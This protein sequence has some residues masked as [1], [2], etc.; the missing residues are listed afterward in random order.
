[1]EYK[2]TTHS[3]FE[4]IELAQNFESE[5][6]PNMVICLDGELGSGK[7]VF[8]K[9][10]GNALGINESITSPT[11]TIIKEYMDGEMP[12]YHMDVYRLDGNTEGVNIEEYYNKGGIVVIEWAKTI[13]SILPEERLEISFKIV[14]ENKRILVITPYGKKYEELCEAVL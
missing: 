2:I 6:F 3:E 8:V 5:K 13:K 7:T 4:T 14:D 12:L 10:L 9:G 11:F 1:M